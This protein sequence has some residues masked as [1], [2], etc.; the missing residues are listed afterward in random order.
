MAKYEGK[1]RDKAAVRYT[2]RG[3]K[4]T[5]AEVMLR[6]DFCNYGELGTKAPTLYLPERDD[7]LAKRIFIEHL[8]ERR[9]NAMDEL[10]KVEQQLNNIREE[11]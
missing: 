8:E 9:L 1:I 11:I 3:G 5:I 10:A 4:F 2:Y 7:E 6:R